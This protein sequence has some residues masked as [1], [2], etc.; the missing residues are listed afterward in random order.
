MEDRKVG[1]SCGD[2]SRETLRE[3]L[4]MPED[5]RERGDVKS[6]DWVPILISSKPSVEP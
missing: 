4:R 2:G 1:E 3:F 5:L 6:Y